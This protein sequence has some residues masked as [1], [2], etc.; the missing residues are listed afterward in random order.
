[1]GV[2]GTGNYIFPLM[3]VDGD[4]VTAEVN[5]TSAG[6]GAG[7]LVVSTYHTVPAN[8]PYPTNSDTWFADVT[9]MWDV[10][11]V[12]N[13]ANAVDRFWLVNYNGYTA[14]PTATLSL[15]YDA[16]GTNDLNGLTETDLQAEYWNGLTWAPYSPL[17]GVVDPANDL[18]NTITGV[19]FNAPWVL[20]N[21]NHPLPV[22]LTSLGFTC[23]TLE[24]TTAS[25]TNCD[26]Y[27]IYSSQNGT[28]WNLIGQVNGAGNSNQSI[29]YSFPTELSGVYFKLVQV[30]LNGAE[31]AYG[32]VWG[33]CNNENL[34]NVSIEVYPNPFNE[35]IYIV[36]P[37]NCELKMYDAVGKLVRNERMQSFNTIE[38]SDLADGLYTL[39]FVGVD[40]TKT[41]KTVKNTH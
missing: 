7:S 34:N 24:W 38:M 12:D 14:N 18:V 9:N 26:Y 2:T 1:M 23:G 13:S 11:G 5:I 3:S 37:E 28:D 33:N 30:D 35:V 15:K 20:S 19:N 21:M 32:P 8:T 6:T 4:N 39:N 16:I 17:L 36:C 41:I 29:H 10:T 27:L 40:F 31:T 25:E 22:D